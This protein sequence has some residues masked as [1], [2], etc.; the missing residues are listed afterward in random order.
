[1]EQK[2]PQQGDY[3]TVED[4]NQ[5]SPIERT[6]TPP[7]HTKTFNMSNIRNLKDRIRSSIHTAEDILATMMTSTQSPSQITLHIGYIKRMSSL[8]YKVNSDLMDIDQTGRD[9]INDT[10]LKNYGNSIIDIGRRASALYK[11]ICTKEESINSAHIGMLYARQAAHEGKDHRRQGAIRIA[12]CDQANISCD[13]DCLVKEVT[14]FRDYL[15]AEDHNIT[16]GARKRV[17]WK[18]QVGLITKALS[19]LITTVNSNNIP[20]T[21]VD[22]S[23]LESKVKALR[24]LLPAVVTNKQEADHPTQPLNLED[25]AKTSKTDQ[26]RAPRN[27]LTGNTEHPM[28]DIKTN[29]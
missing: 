21:D 23:T 6:P 24:H 15:T 16:K 3:L 10:D 26:L 25:A 27:A 29:Y 1:M 8:T 18:G 4:H 11:D 12:K 20:H 13:Y 7:N 2:V 9:H 14:G 17:E 28:I 19:L 22:I 5:P